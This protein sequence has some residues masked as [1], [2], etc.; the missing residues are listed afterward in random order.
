[1]VQQ[2]GDG[3]GDSGR[4]V[5][6]VLAVPVRAANHLIHV[7]EEYSL[8]DRMLEVCLVEL[9]FVFFPHFLDFISERFEA[10]LLP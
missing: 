10:F 8:A 9:V 2:P 4:L 1:M 5:R 7:S 6:A 3:V